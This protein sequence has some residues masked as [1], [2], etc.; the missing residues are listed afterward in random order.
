MLF[1]CKSA[2]AFAA[3]LG[4]VVLVA[5]AAPLSAKPIVKTSF[6]SYSVPGTSAYA[7]LSYMQRN[8]PH[9]N[10]SRALATTSA[11]FRYQADAHTSKG[12]KLKNFRVTTTFVITL[13]KATNASKM[14]SK[15]RRRWGQFVK[16]ARWHENRHKSIWI[17]CAKK[18]E[19]AARSMGNQRSCKAAW[20]KAQAIVK[21]EL[22]RCDRIHATFDRRETAKASKIPLIAQALRAPKTGTR[23]V[24]IKKAL[25]YTH[26]RANDDNR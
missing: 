17:G 10:G 4:A 24:A 2:G 14:P 16:H 3:A 20:S 11:S 6:K 12:C 19:R 23:R 5:G 15:V 26:S 8:G 1:T 9:A 22:A 25:R 13:P 21:K 7:L 18:I